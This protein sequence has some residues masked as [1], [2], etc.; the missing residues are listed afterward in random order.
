V[1]VRT[2]GVERG[3]EMPRKRDRPEQISGKLREV[4]V[5]LAKGQTVAVAVRQIAVTEKTYYRW[6][7]E[8][9]G[10]NERWRIRRLLR[11]AC[12][13]GG[14]SW[15]SPDELSSAMS[16]ARSEGKIE[17][18]DQRLVTAVA[19]EVLTQGGGGRY[20]GLVWR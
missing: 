11:T 10:W 3:I 4:G 14:A 6:P 1:N 5:P 20:P 12:P 9:G 17:R 15:D 13:C 2:S 19:D 7:N 16:Q 8:Y 18:M